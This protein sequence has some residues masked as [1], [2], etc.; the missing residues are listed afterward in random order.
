[1]KNYIFTLVIICIYLTN[2]TSKKEKTKEKT[3]EN[4]SSY[5]V[6]DEISFDETKDDPNFKVC[7]NYI[8]QYFN[9]SDGLVYEGEKPML[10][11]LFF[12][13][14]NSEIVE[15]QS[16]LIRIRFI[17]NCKAETGR[18]RLLGMDNN[19]Q[20]KVFDENIT[21][22]LLNITKD[23]RG[24]GVQTY[25]DMNID[26]YQYIIFVIENGKITKILP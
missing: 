26:Y 1:M 24:W 12:D 9:N 16:G 22:Q 5:E 8:F 23:L 19:Y 15:K 17:V 4:N 14:Y 2:C 13:K 7:N 11:K 20:E 18:F 10:D 21:S 6:V 25:K 3:K